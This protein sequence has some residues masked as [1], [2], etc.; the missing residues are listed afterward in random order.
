MSR[1]QWG[2]GTLYRPKDRRTWWLK[3]WH[4]GKVYTRS[5][6]SADRRVANRMLRE[7]LKA[8]GRGTPTT[9]AQRK[10][11]FSDMQEMLRSDYRRKQNRSWASVR[12]CTGC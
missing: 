6:E 9:N 2:S 3:W 5:S 7:E 1:T 4:A 11:T 8:L 10:A 12:C